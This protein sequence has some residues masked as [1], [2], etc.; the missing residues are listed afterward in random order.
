MGKITDLDTV[1]ANYG[2][3]EILEFKIDPTRVTGKDK[4]FIEAQFAKLGLKVTKM[5]L[6]FHLYL[7]V[8]TNDGRVWLH[9][10]SDNNAGRFIVYRHPRKPKK[11][12]NHV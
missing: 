10:G 5:R 4:K 7:Y 9:D 12:I 11:V 1:V 8:Y 6:E 2:N 3:R